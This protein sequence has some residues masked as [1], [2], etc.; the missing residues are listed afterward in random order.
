MFAPWTI[1]DTVTRGILNEARKGV[2][3]ATGT[4]REE[5]ENDY[6]MGDYFSNFS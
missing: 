6:G 5:V 1:A 3:L 2:A 4:P